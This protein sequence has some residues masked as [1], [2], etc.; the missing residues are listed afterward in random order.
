MSIGSRHVLIVQRF[1][2]TNMKE[3]IAE[4]LSAYGYEIKSMDI[5]QNK[6]RYTCETG[7]IDIWD[8]RKGMT[9]GIYDPNS[10]Q[11]LFE[12]RCSITGI[13]EM[14]SKVQI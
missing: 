12:R 7:F 9:V 1:A 10:K 11:I 14:L 13:E 4:L 3:E 8:G 2:F 5:N 6:T